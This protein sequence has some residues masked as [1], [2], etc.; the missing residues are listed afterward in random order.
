MRLFGTVQFTSGAC[1]FER[2]LHACINTAYTG[3]PSET[4]MISLLTDTNHFAKRQGA[5]L[6][7]GAASVSSDPKGCEQRDHRPEAQGN[8]GGVEGRKPRGSGG[9]GPAG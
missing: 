8:R 2:G 5:S 1:S 9:A 7:F 6:P 3:N 4:T